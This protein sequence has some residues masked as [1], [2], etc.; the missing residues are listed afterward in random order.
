MDRP[1]LALVIS[2]QEPVTDFETGD[3]FTLYAILELADFFCHQEQLLVDCV[4]GFFETDENSIRS[5]DLDKT[6]RWWGIDLRASQ[7]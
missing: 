1:T 5:F 6:H 3:D 4:S 2:H 7:G